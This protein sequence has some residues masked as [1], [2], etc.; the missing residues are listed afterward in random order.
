MSFILVDFKILDP[1]GPTYLARHHTA[2]TRRAGHSWLERSHTPPTYF[3]PN[4]Q[5]PPRMRLCTFAVSTFGAFGREAL[6]L[7]SMIAARAGG[8]VPVAFLDEATWATPSCAPFLRSSIATCLRSHLAAQ[9]RDA[10]MSA[11]EVDA[12][13]GPPY[14]PPADPSRSFDAPE[15]AEHDAP[16]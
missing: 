15:L 1:A 8:L 4:G 2:D 11:A 16:V 6:A 3:G 9:L 7:L 14:V 10:G 13:E 5:P 12:L